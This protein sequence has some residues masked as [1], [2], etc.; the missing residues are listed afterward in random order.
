MLLTYRKNIQR[1][2]ITVYVNSLTLLSQSQYVAMR[3][4]ANIPPNKEH[5]FRSQD[6]FKFIL[7]VPIIKDLSNAKLQHYYH[8]YPVTPYLFAF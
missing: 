7:I 5:S 8:F 3:H 6:I 4:L 2:L 1:M